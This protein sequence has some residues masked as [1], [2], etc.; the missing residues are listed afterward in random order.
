VTFDLTFCSHK[1]TT[2]MGWLWLVIKLNQKQVDGNW[3]SFWGSPTECHLYEELAKCHAASI[4]I[5]QLIIPR[6]PLTLLSST[7]CI[8]LLLIHLF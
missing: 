1:T 2:K 6:H 3:N 7:Y 4:L 8:L 5:Q